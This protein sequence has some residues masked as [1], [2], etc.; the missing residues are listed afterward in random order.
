VD[1]IKESSLAVIPLPIARSLLFL[2]P[3]SA[4]SASSV[5]LGTELPDI[6]IRQEVHHH[7]IALLHREQLTDL[8]VSAS[9]R[10]PSHC[11]PPLLPQRSLLVFPSAAV[12][13]EMLPRL[14]Y[15]PAS[16]ASPPALVIVS[17]TEPFQVH[18]HP[19]V[20]GLQSVEPGCQR[21]HTI[22]WDGSLASSYAFQSIAVGLTE[23]FSLP[24]SLRCR[25]CFRD[26][27][28]PVG[29]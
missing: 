20:S 21:F 18:P 25:L 27:S 9:A 14:G 17:A 2:R 13:E 15:H 12:A 19:R 16:T 7:F 29:R 3:L 28:G 1:E 23:F 10:S 8:H 24:L 6:S 11:L 4:G 22:H 26:S 5:H